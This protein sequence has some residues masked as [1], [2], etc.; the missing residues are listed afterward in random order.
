MRYYSELVKID[1]RLQQIEEKLDK[2]MEEF[3]LFKR[4]IDIPT[5]N[6]SV[7]DLPKHLQTTFLTLHS[8]KSATAGMIATKTNKARAVES[9]YLNQLVRL[10]YISKRRNG[11]KVIFTALT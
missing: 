7:L 6:K 3:E 2:L 11:R 8:L 1:K 5:E 4:S 9:S 10:G